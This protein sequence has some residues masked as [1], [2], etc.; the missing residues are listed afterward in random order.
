[1]TAVQC[2]VAMYVEDGWRK[3]NRWMVVCHDAGGDAAVRLVK[4]SLV[5]GMECCGAV[6]VEG[7]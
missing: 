6:S 1:M 7:G 2:H 3:L 5:L 4:Y